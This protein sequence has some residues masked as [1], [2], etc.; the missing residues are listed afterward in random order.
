[1]IIRPRRLS[2]L[3]EFGTGEL[4]GDMKLL[5]DL[6]ER[7]VLFDRG[8]D[9]VKHVPEAWV[10][11]LEVGGGQRRS[12]GGLGLEQAGPIG[13]V[14]CLIETEFSAVME[15]WGRDIDKHRCGAERQ[16]DFGDDRIGL[17]GSAD[18]DE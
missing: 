14:R 7:D 5:H 13:R 10:L 2:E 12:L 11:G 4:P 16:W 15:A 9:E 17:R 18:A 8:L 3:G 6:D 1:M